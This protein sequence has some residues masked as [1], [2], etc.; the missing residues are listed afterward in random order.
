MRIHLAFY[1]SLL[2]PTASDGLSGQQNPPPPPPPPIK[3]EWKYQGE[4][5][6]VLKSGICRKNFQYLVKC[7]EFDI[8]NWYPTENLEYLRE[9]T[10]KFHF[11]YPQKT[12]LT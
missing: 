10:N 12:D 6:A 7:V 4:V 2:K 8:S 3:V 5:E 9:L 11:W 1:V